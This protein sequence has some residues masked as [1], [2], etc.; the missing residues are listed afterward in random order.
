MQEIKSG[1]RHGSHEELESFR[2][3]M[4]RSWKAISREKQ[5]ELEEWKEEEGTDIQGTG[6][7]F[8]WQ[9]STTGAERQ[10]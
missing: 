2:S 9:A 6:R 7:A 5:K 3:R 10:F 8:V 1:S 4:S